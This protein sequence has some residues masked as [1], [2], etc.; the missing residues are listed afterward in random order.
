MAEGFR[1]EINQKVDAKARVSIPAPFRRIIEAEDPDYRPGTSRP[2][3]VLVY[4][5]REPM[6]ECYTMTRMAELE[7][8]ILAMEDGTRE[9]RYLERNMMTLSQAM[10][11]DDD[12]RIVLPQKGREKLQLALDDLKGGVEAVFA[13]ALTRFQ[14]WTSEAYAQE[15]ARRDAEDADLLGEGMHM[16]SLLPK[17]A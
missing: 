12:G 14:I 6:L 4:G 17:R 5:G 3:F 10:E 11:V 1:G 9:R 15:L 2:R 16:T 7:S 13:G 8:R